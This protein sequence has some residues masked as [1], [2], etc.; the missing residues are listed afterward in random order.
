VSWLQPVVNLNKARSIK[1]SEFR[2]EQYSRMVD[3]ADMLGNCDMVRKSVG[4]IDQNVDQ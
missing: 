1:M 2:L 4:N 3:V